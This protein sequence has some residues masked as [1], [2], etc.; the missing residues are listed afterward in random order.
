MS[1]IPFFNP[2]LFS[3]VQ[4]Y[5]TD[6]LCFSFLSAFHSI[7][8]GV[9]QHHLPKFILNFSS[10][11]IFLTPKSFLL[12]IEYSFFIASCFCFTLQCFLL[13]LYGDTEKDF[14]GFSSPANIATASSESF[15]FC[16]I[17]SL[18]IDVFLGAWW[19]SAVRHCYTNRNLSILSRTFD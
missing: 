2:L 7:C 14:L 16:S 10:S 11:V 3:A 17:T 18:M 5:Q 15:V 4:L 12:L 9:S 19:S 8:G 1:F 13:C 6:P